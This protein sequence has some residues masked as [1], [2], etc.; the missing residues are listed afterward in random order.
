MGL[1]KAKLCCVGSLV[2]GLGLFLQG[3]QAQAGLVVGSESLAGSA[4][5]QTFDLTTMSS[6]KFSGFVD[7][8]G[9]GGTNTLDFQDHVPAFTPILGTVT[10]N[11]LVGPSSFTISN[12]A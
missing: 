9:S 7:T 6:I 4:T 5:G 1:K 8:G 2:V 3:Q 10:L 11:F 12:A